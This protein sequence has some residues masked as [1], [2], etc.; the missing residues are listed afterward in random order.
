MRKGSGH[1]VRCF[2]QSASF[3][4][5]DSTF[6]FPHSVFRNSAFYQHPLYVCVVVVEC[7]LTEISRW[8]GVEGADMKGAVWE[9]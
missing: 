8:W 1:V 2:D 4:I 9:R 7:E 5:F 6:Y 3:R